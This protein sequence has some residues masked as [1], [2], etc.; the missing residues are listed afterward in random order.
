MSRLK[1]L[2]MYAGLLGSLFGFS[3]T[4]SLAQTAPEGTSASLLRGPEQRVAL[5]IGDAHYKNAPELANPDNDAHAM[6]QFLNK[7][8]FE[9]NSA[10]ELTQ[11]D[12]IR[13]VQEFPSTV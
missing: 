8:G 9:I 5:V 1:S 13:D 3:I 11:S 2:L 4:G 6:G 7:A 12:T 10:V